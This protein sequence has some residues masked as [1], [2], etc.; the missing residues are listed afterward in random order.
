MHLSVV[1]SRPELQNIYFSVMRKENDK[2][3][4]KKEQQTGKKRESREYAQAKVVYFLVSPTVK[5]ETFHAWFSGLFV[6]TSG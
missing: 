3:E 1:G 2:E 6:G 4:Q 5:D